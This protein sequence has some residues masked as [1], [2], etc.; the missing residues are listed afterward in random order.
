MITTETFLSNITQGVP[1]GNY[2]GS[3]LDFDSDAVQGPGYYFGHSGQQTL[4]FALSGFS[5]ALLIQGTLDSDAGRANWVDLYDFED[6]AI[7]TVFT[8]DVTGKFV[9]LRCRVSA[10]TD[11]TIDQVT[12]A[13]P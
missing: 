1:S 6:A 9:W 5:G 7:T 10:F 8:V 13:Y 2:D 3:S 4:T 12:V 11:G